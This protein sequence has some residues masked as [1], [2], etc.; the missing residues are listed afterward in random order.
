M[1][2]PDY[3]QA[4]VGEVGAEVLHKNQFSSTRVGLDT[5]VDDLTVGF[6]EDH[7]VQ[8]DLRSKERGAFWIASIDGSEERSLL[9]VEGVVDECFLVRDREAVVHQHVHVVVADVDVVHLV[10]MVRGM[11]H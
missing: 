11:A 1:R 5:P 3:L 4:F 8:P 10:E 2:A 6:V 9:E 7:L